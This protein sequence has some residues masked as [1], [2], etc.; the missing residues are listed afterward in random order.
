MVLG[1]CRK[2][3]LEFNIFTRMSP[4]KLNREDLPNFQGDLKLH[5]ALLEQRLLE[6]SPPVKYVWIYVL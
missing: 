1:Y 5:I 4:K 3:R 6:P 2:K